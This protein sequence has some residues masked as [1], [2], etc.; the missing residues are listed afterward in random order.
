M[1]ESNSSESAVRTATAE[2]SSPYSNIKR[3]FTN[4]ELFFEKVYPGCIHSESVHLLYYTTI[5]RGHFIAICWGCINSYYNTH[6]TLHSFPIGS[7]TQISNTLLTPYEKNF[8]LT[9]QHIET[10]L[11]TTKFLICEKSKYIN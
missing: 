9:S 11:K 5:R 10:I 2:F 3:N 4:E 8:S 7:T 6:I 1:L